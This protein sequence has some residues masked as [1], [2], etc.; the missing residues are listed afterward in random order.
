MRPRAEYEGRF[1]ESEVM[2]RLAK[3]YGFSNVEIEVFPQP[4]Q[5]LWQATQAEL[6]LLTP[7]PRKLYDFRDVAVT[8]ASGSESGDVT[9]DLVDVGNGGRPDDYAGKD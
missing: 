3:E 8:I 4:N 6:W 1:R 2:A 5:R 9:A 7:A